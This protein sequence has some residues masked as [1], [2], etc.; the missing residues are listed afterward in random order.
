MFETLFPK[1]QALAA[2]DQMQNNITKNIK[3]LNNE[4]LDTIESN[5]MNKMNRTLM[6][7]SVTRPGLLE[8]NIDRSILDICEEAR[9][10]EML[11]I[12]V[13]VHINQIY[14]KYNTIRLVYESVLCVVLDYNKILSSLS[15]KERILFKALIHAC[16]RKIMPGIYKLTWGAEMIDAYIAEC[17]KQ[18][19]LVS[20]H[21]LL[22]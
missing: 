4:W 13:P 19:G 6:C 11:G 2:Y 8:C 21:I 15:D 12:G 3:Q 14:S 5:V 1:F 9:Y 7:R 17:V 22:K 20:G 16:E 18:T 10:F